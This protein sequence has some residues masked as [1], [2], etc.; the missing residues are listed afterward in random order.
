MSL[1]KE[2]FIVSVWDKINKTRCDA[3]DAVQEVAEANEIDM[4]TAGKLVGSN[5]AL[6]KL[7][8]SQAHQMNQLKRPNPSL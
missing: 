2:Q 5:S 4:E 7:I 6:K 3:L 8:E 1:S